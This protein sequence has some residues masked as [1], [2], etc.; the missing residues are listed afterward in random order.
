[1]R[2]VVRWPIVLPKGFRARRLSPIL[3]M[4]SKYPRLFYLM[5]RLSHSLVDTF[6]IRSRS[7]TASDM[8]WA[9]S[10]MW[11][12]RKFQICISRVFVKKI[13]SYSLTFLFASASVH[14]GEI[15]TYHEYEAFPFVYRDRKLSH[16][17]HPLFF[18]LESRCYSGACILKIPAYF[19]HLSHFLTKSTTSNFILGQQ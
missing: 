9:S 5:H 15:V 1:M 7:L 6:G 14:F 13:T 4:S 8:N 18:S 16:N 19:W 10:L 12:L 3:N 11:I 2:E 17:V